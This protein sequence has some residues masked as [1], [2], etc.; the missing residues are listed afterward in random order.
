MIVSVDARVEQNNMLRQQPL[1]VVL[2]VV[3]QVGFVPKRQPAT[4][5]RK[6]L[7]VSGAIGAPRVH[8]TQPS[9]RPPMDTTFRLSPQPTEQGPPALLLRIAMV[10]R[11]TGL[12]R[13]TI[14]RMVANADFPS[15]VRLTNRAVAWRR[16]DLEKWSESRPQVAH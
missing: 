10:V 12:G 11:M 14:Y 3:E 2:S 7:Q 6:F 8:L 5:Y 9:R 1:T 4:I 13:S 16:T 15:P